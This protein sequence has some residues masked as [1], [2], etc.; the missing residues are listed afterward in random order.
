MKRYRH[1]W[2]D[3]WG[4]IHHVYPP[5]RE[6]DGTPIYK[7]IKQWTEISNEWNDGRL[8]YQTFTT[9]H[10]LKKIT[11]DGRQQRIKFDD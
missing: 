2:I 8:V 1:K 5:P 10:L 7:Q 3:E 4:E 11:K 9:Y 6:K